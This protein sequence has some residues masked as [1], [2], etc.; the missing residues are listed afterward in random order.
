MTASRSKE[1]YVGVDLG[2]G[3][4]K[5]VIID[6]RARILGFGAGDY[7]KNEAP[8]G[9]KEQDPE[10]L[11][12]A[13]IR[14]VR[15]AIDRA[16]VSPRACRGISVGGAFHSLIAIDKSRRPLTGIST[17]V[18]PRA[19]SQAQA[20]RARADADRFYRQTGCPVH[21]MYPAYKLIRLRE[22]NPHIFIRVAR[23]VSA[24]AYIIERLTGRFMIDFSVASGSGM[25]NIHD[26]NW[27]TESLQLAGI[28]PEQLSTVASPWT[29]INGIDPDFAAALGIS[30]HVPLVLGS[31]DAA[32]SSL[33]A[34]AVHSDCA[35]CMVG[36][37]GAYRII[38]KKVVLDSAGRSWCYALDPDHWLV[39]GSINNGG[40][41]LS[42]LREAL[43][44]AVPS[45]HKA[46]KLSYDELI[47][48]AVGINAGADGLICLPFL[49]GERS[50][51]WNM[52][53]RGV[54][55]GL[56]LDHSLDHM[57]R[58]LLEGV[59]FRLRSVA[60]VLDE[61]GCE[62]NEIRV[63]GG[64]TGSELWPQIIASVLD[65]QLHIPR[66][67]ETSSLGAALWA[68]LGTGEIDGFE[69]IEELIP[70][71]RSY[72]PLAA[73]AQ[74]YNELYRVYK[75]LYTALGPSFDKIADLYPP[76]L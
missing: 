7:S 23:F 6:A 24:K 14:A 35:T 5:S 58:A 39:G 70:L 42:W 11:V 2:T 60:E 18:D 68:L 56:T 50:P 31:S 9:W 49:T 48:R 54:F 37:S 34:G 47:N 3:S 13:F 55:F 65:L 41:V 10:T 52:N 19:V 15:N 25:L 33:G 17:W 40:I 32:N 36:T 20:V 51:N 29:V 74:R 4:C 72:S 16:A 75:A 63:S 12:D 76:G 8:T 64:L 61:I 62:T 53:A 46:A 1:W 71:E 26:L 73:D 28:T 57:T 43:N 66:W 45:G 22:E 27:N 30:K 59:A 38:A 69:R 21:S 44:R 67:G